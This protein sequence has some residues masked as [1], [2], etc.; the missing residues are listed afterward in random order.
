MKRDNVF[1]LERGIPMTLTTALTPLYPRE[2]WTLPALLEKQA[3]ER[4]RSP[5]LRWTHEEEPLDFLTVNA[6]TNQVAHGLR[7]WGINKDDRVVIF[8]GNSLSHV[9]CWFACAKLG[10]VDVPINESLMGG[11]LAHQVNLCRATVAIVDERLVER[12]ASIVNDLAYLRRVVVVGDP[13]HARA[14]FPDREVVSLD[15]VTSTNVANPDRVVVPSDPATIMFTSGTTGPSK[16]VLLPHG[17]LHINAE[18][19][20][21]LYG[22]TQDDIFMSPFPLFHGSGRQNS[23]Y[24]MLLVG[25]LCTLYPKFSG[26]RFL[27]RAKASNATITMFHGSMLQM[28]ADQPPSPDDRAHRLRA[29]ICIPLPYTLQETFQT[30]FGIHALKEAIGMTETSL[31]IIPPPGLTPPKG[32]AGCLISE[33]Y[34]ACVA[35]P[36]TD[37]PV[38]DGTMGELLIRPKFPWTTMIAYENMPAETVSANRNLW[39]HTGD[40]VR[41]TSDGWYGFVDRIKDS[42]RRR[43]ENISSFEVEYQLLMHPAVSECAVV[44]VRTSNEM[45]DEEVKACIVCRDGARLDAVELVAWCET[46][47]PHFAVPRYVEFLDALPKT[48]TGKTQKNKLRADALNVRTW[49]RVAAAVVAGTAAS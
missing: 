29:A 26:T 14:M 18:Q 22:L 39:F 8:M 13:A 1:P 11:F 45:K 41:R 10:A 36:E 20:V 19:I 24:P 23:L 9:Y 6:R 30:R 48:P 47:L 27:E 44:S 4:G 31:P 12:L 5:F 3:A 2:L 38:P 17:A 7:A 32:Y 28:V 21:T 37:E 42:I 49:D 15:E 46:K 33:W 34:D 40:G 25:G 35:D 43:G 16:G